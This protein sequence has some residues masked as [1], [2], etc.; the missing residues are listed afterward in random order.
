MN[1]FIKKNI[2]IIIAIFILLGPILDLITGVCLHTFKLN[3]TL[4]IIVRVLFLLFICIITLFTFKKKNILI[5]YLIIGLYFVLY[6]VGMIFFKDTS[7]FTEVQNLVKVFYFPIIFLSLYSIKDKVD[8]DNKILI[9]TVFLYLI[10]ILIPTVFGIGYK[11][12]EITKAGTLGFFNS[13]NEISG[14]ISILTPV[15]FIIMFSSKK[16]IPKIILGIMYLV[17][18]L[19]M[20]SL[21]PSLRLQLNT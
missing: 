13:A 12:Y 10:L 9:K 16:Y 11:T 20:V 19:I 5:P 17:V 8:I 7:L 4:G 14:I 3:L 2:N 21:F 18:I 15:M 1:A 6:T